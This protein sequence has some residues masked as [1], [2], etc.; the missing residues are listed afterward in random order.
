MM[1]TTSGRRSLTLVLS[2]LTCVM[3][4]SLGQPS[5][6]EYFE[7][8]IRPLFVAKCQA[9][10]SAAPRMAG[11]D[12]R[13]AEGFQ[14]GADSGVLINGVDP[15]E[16]RLLR[17]VS[18]ENQIKMP[19]TGRLKTEEIDAIREWVRMG[20]P[21]PTEKAAA[22]QASH[23]KP[24]SDLSEQ[25]K[26]WSFQPVH[27]VAPP[28]V[29][30]REWGRN[31]ID[32]FILAKL[33]QKKLK[34][35][36]PA[37]KATLLRRATFDL[38]GLPPTEAEIRSF[39][40][41]TSPQAFAR[42]ID[43]LMDS[44]RYGER[45]GRHWMDV[46]R[47]ADSTGADE[48][49]RYPY[50]WR[51]RDYVI[52]SFN[53]DVPYDQFMR[54]QVA[55][56]LLPA[57]KPGEVNVRGLVAT[58]FLALG[59]KLIAEQD[60]IKM[61]YDIVD[62]QID[63]T[64]RAFL[65]LTVAC[66]RCHD[67]KFDPISTKDYY[68]LASIFASS[69]QLA[70]LEGTV[71]ALYFA[72]LVPKDVADKYESHQAKIA[73]K[74]KEINDLLAQESEKYRH[75]LAPRLAQYMLAA[76]RVY[77]NGVALEKAASESHLDSDILGKWAEYLKP[78]AERRAHLEAWYN[79]PAAAREQTAAEYQKSFIATATLRRQAMA[80]WREESIVAKATGKDAPAKPKFPAGADRFFTEVASGKGPFALPEKDREK[81]MSEAGR[82]RL[83]L[84]EDDLKQLKSSAPPEPPLACA[85]T[86]GKIT[87]QRVFIRG[88]PENRGDLV[89]KRFPL[90]L[91]SNRQP[92]ITSGS[93]RRELA[94]W[95]ADPANPLP[96]RVMANRIWQWHFGEGIVHTSSNFGKAGERPTNPELLDYLAA[97]F[98]E[99]GWSIKS[100]HRLLMLSNAYQ[101]SSLASPETLERD[102]DDSLLSRFPGR[103]L[104]VE[105]IRDTLLALDGSLDLTMGGALLT[106]HGTDKEFSDDRMSLN[107]DQ[108]KRRTVYLP[109]RRSNLASVLTLFDFGDATTPGEGRSQTNVAPQALYM[110][111]SEFVA[112]QA[113]SMAGQLLED[114]AL[115]DTGRIRC[116]YYRVLG[117]P[118]QESE[119]R[120]ALEYVRLF[121]GKSDD[122]AGRLL[123]WT[124]FCRALVASNDF[125]YIR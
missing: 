110:M 77:R 67:H 80:K 51:Y 57:D 115:D 91:A 60:K 69:K 100:M 4:L 20:A 52:D 72:P 66:A 106:G 50:A 30:D 123:A 34:P 68:S 47:Y 119:V 25:R 122:Q 98:I 94:D 111:N 74:E 121:P 55:G 85:L 59:P 78:V 70:K 45:W 7:T 109:L 113:R 37:D 114:G 42:V 71:S 39:L 22:T 81:V 49:H 32:A 82:T 102:A 2:S 13:S 61:F 54:E 117:R 89:P 95:L 116:A 108:S 6:T 90:V 84:L 112:K 62:E 125:L 107:P 29:R 35:A 9:C 18:Y 24:L 11:L 36:P 86:E 120:R 103:R 124:S 26:F 58:G 75:A 21:W 118:A 19:P 28:A 23:A 63:V 73:D 43:R 17:A 46:A 53:R 65:G 40:E 41:D 48:D 44:P 31:P 38:T 88:N 104:E 101:M 3:R 83:A 93:G 79:A 56:D 5:G 10:H 105:E 96:A 76:G 8:K 87:E 16:S 97:S 14:R 1:Y 33:E 92:P 64:T 27:K 99:R 15:N 12:L